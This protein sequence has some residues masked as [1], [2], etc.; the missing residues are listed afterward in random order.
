LVGSGARREGVNE[1]FHGASVFTAAA[2]SARSSFANAGDFVLL[3]DPSNQPVQCVH[4]GKF[5]EMLP[6]APLIDAAPTT[7]K[8][9][10]QRE[11]LAGQFKVH[12]VV[13]GEP[14]TAISPGT[15]EIGPP[16]PAKPEAA[17]D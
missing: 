13:K 7:A 3:S 12:P 1:D 2:A 14:E 5:T 15:F 10:V 6:D 8:G 16:A 9:S 11:S 4:W 17:G